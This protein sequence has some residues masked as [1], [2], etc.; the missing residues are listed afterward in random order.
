M[1]P[2][3]IKILLIDI[4]SIVSYV[5]V[6]TYTSLN[7]SNLLFGI[8]LSFFSIVYFF[9]QY[10]FIKKSITN[11]INKIFLICSVTKM[12]VLLVGLLVLLLLFKEYAKFITISVLTLYVLFTINEIHSILATIKTKRNKKQ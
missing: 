2:Y 9:S 12:A 7:V 8:I 5:I 11:N 10:V 4:L 6:S 1:K 3:T